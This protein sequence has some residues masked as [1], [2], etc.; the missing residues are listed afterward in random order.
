MTALVYQCN[1][2]IIEKYS[3]CT[4]IP[5]LTMRVYL[6]SFSHCCLPK[7]CSSAKCWENLNL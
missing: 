1:L 7:M 5:S 4:T 2:Y 3:Q 6:H